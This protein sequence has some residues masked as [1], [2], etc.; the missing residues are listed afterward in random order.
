MALAQVGSRDIDQSIWGRLFG[1]G[2]LLVCGS[3]GKEFRIC[4]IADPHEL[5]C[6]HLR[7]YL[8]PDRLRSPEALGVLRYGMVTYGDPTASHA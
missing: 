7:P 8:L 4:N 3:G 6:A 1:F 5:L 2:D